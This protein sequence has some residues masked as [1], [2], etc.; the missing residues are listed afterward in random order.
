M[1]CRG[2]AATCKSVSCADCSSQA[3]RKE[4]RTIRHDC[5]REKRLFLQKRQDAASCRT[6]LLRTGVQ[7]ALAV[8]HDWRKAHSVSWRHHCRYDLSWNGRV[9]AFSVCGVRSSGRSSLVQPFL[10]YFGSWDAWAATTTRA[11]VHAGPVRRRALSLAFLCVTVLLLRHAPFPA[12]VACSVM[13]GLIILPV[14]TLVSH[15]KGW[16]AYCTRSSPPEFFFCLLG[17]AAFCHI[18]RRTECTQCGACTQV[19]RYGALDGSRWR[20]EARGPRTFLVRDCL[21]VCTH[22][23]LCMTWL[24]MEEGAS[25]V[26]WYL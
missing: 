25:G 2:L 21:N 6:R 1:S 8:F 26:L 22:G 15:R 7:K 14:S 18:R 20:P 10:C 12:A 11:S 13:L 19:C 9:Y 16:V 17:R 24:G 5:R 3:Y 4:G 23:G